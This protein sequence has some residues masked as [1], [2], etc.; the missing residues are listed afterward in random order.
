[1]VKDYE[2]SIGFLGPSRL[3]NILSRSG[4]VSFPLVESS[5]RRLF[6]FSF[7][8]YLN[9]DSCFSALFFLFFPMDASRKTR[10]GR[11]SLRSTLYSSYSRSSLVSYLHLVPSEGD[12]DES[13][14]LLV[15]FGTKGHEIESL[16]AKK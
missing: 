16:S 2:Y 9:R 1:M 6:F 8:L 3:L 14:E 5:S 11:L 7:S 10:L 12:F 4:L 13:N 15:R